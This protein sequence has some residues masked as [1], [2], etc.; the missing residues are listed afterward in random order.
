MMVELKM[1]YIMR[2]GI[3]ILWIVLWCPLLVKGQGVEFR[4]LTFQQALE[5]AQKENKPLL[6][7]CYTSWCGP[8]QHMLKDVFTLPEAG[9]FMNT[10]FVCVKFDMEKGEGIDL[11]KR[12]EIRAYPTFLIIRPDGVVVHRLVGGGKWENFRQ[13]LERGLNEKTSLYYLEQCYQNGKLSSKQNEDYLVALKDASYDKQADEFGKNIFASLS[14]KQKCK[15]EN[16]FVYD[17]EL[18]ITDERIVFLI[19]HKSM[20]DQTV[21]KEAVDKKLEEVYLCAL[22]KLHQANQGEWFELASVLDAQFKTVDFEG[23]RELMYYWDYLKAFYAQDIEKVLEGMENHWGALSRWIKI[24]LL[25]RLD[26]IL[27]RGSD[28]Q[29]QRYIALGRKAENDPDTYPQLVEIFKEVFDKYQYEWENRNAYV[30]IKG[31][32]SKHKM[33]KVYLYEVVDGKEALLATTQVGKDGLYGFSF[34]P[35]YAGFYTVGGENP[36]ERIRLYLCP[37]D[38][39]TVNILED[40]L[41]IAKWNTAENNLLAEWEAMITPVRRRVEHLDYIL[42]D[43]RDFFPYFMEFLPKAREFR[44]KISSKD[45]AFAELLKKTV[46]YD[47]DYCAFNILNVIKIGKDTH[48]LSRPELSDYPAYYETIVDK[49]KLTDASVLQQPYGYDYLIKYTTF[50][51][52]N[53]GKA[54]LADRLEWLSCDLLKAEMVLWYAESAKTYEAYMKIVRKYR[55]YLTTE[56]HQKRM[57]A[58]SARLYKGEKGK[59]AADFTYPDKDG[60]MVSLSDFK[61][62]VVVV[63]VWATWCGPCR[64]EVPYLVELEK[65]MEGKDLVFIGVSVDE[66]KNYQKWLDVL[67]KEGLNGIQLFAD[68]WSQITKDYKIEGIPR[69]MVFDR[70]GKVVTI[71]APRPSNPELKKMLQRLLKK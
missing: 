31:V 9:E 40:T 65:E 11:R 69:F 22:H 44:E 37:G 66:K 41:V 32:V 68:G 67:D 28:E 1:K 30:A 5:T 29:I 21:G 62:K 19:G 58:V 33:E 36:Q 56:N 15:G 54:S 53:K 35:S 43:Y 10:H 59:E 13:R 24:D 46:D 14:K 27:E 7:D 26:Y 18:D 23:K 3:I 34:Q 55:E 52:P 42:F 25:G 50:A 70:E 57:A 38:E 64:K 48:K 51:C 39:G 4:P 49:E 63:D 17:Q 20:F 60:K 45:E 61:G 47:L 6:L 8:C 71:D 2:S 16:W 12:F